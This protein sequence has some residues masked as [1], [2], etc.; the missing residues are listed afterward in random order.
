MLRLFPSISAIGSLIVA[1]SANAFCIGPTG[2]DHVADKPICL[3]LSSVD[4]QEGL[5]SCLPDSFSS[6]NESTSE[7]LVWTVVQDGQTVNYQAE[8][9]SGA[10]LFLGKIVQESPTKAQLIIDIRIHS[11]DPTGKASL[12]TD[13]PVCSEDAIDRWVGIARAIYS[14][15]RPLQ[16]DLIE[17][18]DQSSSTEG[19]LRNALYARHHLL[20]FQSSSPSFL[21]PPQS[22]SSHWSYESLLQPASGTT[23]FRHVTELQRL[24]TSIDNLAMTQYAGTMYTSVPGPIAVLSRGVE[25]IISR[26]LQFTNSVGIAVIFMSVLVRISLL[27]ISYW[28][29]ANQKRFSAISE[30]MNPEIKGIRELYKGAEQSERILDVYKKHGVSPFSALRASIGLFFQIPFLLAV[31]NVTNESSI[32]LGAEFL[33]IS[34]ISSAD[35]IAQLPFHIPYFGSSL[36]ALPLALGFVN[37]F[38]SRVGGPPSSQSATLP[39]AF[40]LV[41][42]LL[43]YTVS[44]ALVLY[45]L[46]ANI[47]QIVERIA[48][49]NFMAS[50]V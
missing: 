39:T 35:A 41:I 37:I 9:N 40:S 14:F 13:V 2:A 46:A 47:M 43:F 45:W 6:T 7:Q 29:F 17:G 1:S 18:W 44:S 42:V 15:Q 27:P 36:N 5:P 26:V 34:D 19:A 8:S 48:F 4:N 31:Y 30:K 50:R 38:S 32:F 21:R 12:I 24:D 25:T 33:W 11:V 22:D 20:G 49:E 3:S 16:L 10:W 23:M 28:S